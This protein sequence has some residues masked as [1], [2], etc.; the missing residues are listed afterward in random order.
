MYQSHIKEV[1]DMCIENGWPA[2]LYTLYDGASPTLGRYL[3]EAGFDARGI[4]V[5]IKEG[6]EELINWTGPDLNA[7]RRMIV[8]P[9]LTKLCLEMSGWTK[10]PKTEEPIDAFNHGPD[11][12]RYLTFYIA[13]GEPDTV[14]IAAEGVDMDEI[15][16]MVSRVMAEANKKTE[17]ILKEI[18][19]TEKSHGFQR[20]P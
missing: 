10:N 6:V 12:A 4:R 15:E 13:N 2:P 11:G 14:T 5:K 1:T 7:I 3:K 18:N 16:E 19:K 9:R 17:E 20:V 8:H